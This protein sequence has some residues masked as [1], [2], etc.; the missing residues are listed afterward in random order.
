MDLM[1]M[2]Q[3]LMVWGLGSMELRVKIGLQLN[4]QM[5]FV[6]EETLIY[7]LN[8]I[9]QA[10]YSLAKPAQDSVMFILQAVL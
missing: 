3:R 7:L 2:L 10:I 8:G 4:R 5:A 1:G 9:F 6:L